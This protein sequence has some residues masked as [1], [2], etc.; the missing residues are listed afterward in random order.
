MILARSPLRITIA[1]GSTDFPEYSDKYGG[2]VLSLAINKYVYVNI[3]QPFSRKI[4]LKYSESEKVNNVNNVK[5]IY[6]KELLKNYKIKNKIEITTLADIP[7]GTGLGSSGSFTT[8]CILALNELNGIS[9]DKKTLAE[10]AAKFEIKKL[11]MNVG[12]QDQYIS[13]YGGMR[14]LKFS[15]NN[16]R[17]LTFKIKNSFKKKLIKNSLL[18]FTGYTRSASK[19]LSDHK[20]S[21]KILDEKYYK[22]MKFIKSNCKDVK[23]ALMNCDLNS[24]TDLINEQWIEKKRRDKY[25]SNSKINSLVQYGLRNGAKCGKL[26]GA[27]GGGFVYFYSNNLEKL[28]KKLKSVGKNQ[29]IT[30]DEDNQG[31][32]I[33]NI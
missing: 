6:L 13:A 2:E 9:P 15:K 10:S 4:Y 8:A 11:K 18:V 19:I 27:G 26:L 14:L 30:F 22:K 20:N 5:H 29:I 25:I 7:A 3:I 12:R 31:T 33:L 1:G 23:Q 24:F 16:N 28:K 32:K 21:L 17:V